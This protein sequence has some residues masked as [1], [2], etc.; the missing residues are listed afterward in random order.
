MRARLWRK[1]YPPGSTLTHLTVFLGIIRP[2]MNCEFI[3]H[4]QRSPL[5]DS[6]LDKAPKP[7]SARH[8]RPNVVLM[9][10]VRQ[11]MNTAGLSTMSSNRSEKVAPPSSET[12]RIRL[13]PDLDLEAVVDGVGLGGS[14]TSLLTVQRMSRYVTA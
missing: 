1:P 7:G 14:C 3:E 9:P 4:A 8:N 13:N 2:A 10:G 12:A 11:W 6:W 5:R